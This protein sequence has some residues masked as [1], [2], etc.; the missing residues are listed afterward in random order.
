MEQFWKWYTELLGF[1]ALRGCKGPQYN[2][3]HLDNLIRGPGEPTLSLRVKLQDKAL[4]NEEEEKFSDILDILI[5]TYIKVS[6][7]VN[8]MKKFHS[9]KF[10][11]NKGLSQ[12]YQELEKMASE[13]VT[14]PDKATFN[15]CFINGIPPKWKREIIAHDRIRAD[16]SSPQEMRRAASRID[17]VI[18]GLKMASAY[19]SGSYTRYA[20]ETMTTSRKKT[21]ILCR[22]NPIPGRHEASI[23]REEEML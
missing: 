5:R 3:V 17:E 11:A 7:V 4:L 23:L 22:K 2:K 20:Q 13:T 14:L 6:T 15:A 16:F 19:R 18:D 1:L 21:R 10:D 8:M 12:F 9:I